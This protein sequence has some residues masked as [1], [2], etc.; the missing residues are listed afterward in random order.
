M[1]TKYITSCTRPLV[2]WHLRV[3]RS[4][5][6]GLC[7]LIAL[8]RTSCFPA[9]ASPRQDRGQRYRT[10]QNAFIPAISPHRVFNLPQ[11]LGVCAQT[12]AKETGQLLRCLAYPNSC[13][14]YLV[15]SRPAPCT[16]VGQSNHS[17]TTYSN[18]DYDITTTGNQNP[19]FEHVAVT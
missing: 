3:N 1:R 10:T 13:R 17:K 9:A 6:R 8:W 2:W 18:L 16:T 19:D 4:S 11:Q 15:Y 14:L 12:L 7:P 5:E